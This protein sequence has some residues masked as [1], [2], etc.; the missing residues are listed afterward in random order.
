ME[1]LCVIGHPSFV[2]GADTELDHQIRC[3]VAM[4]KKVHICHT[5]EMDRNCLSMHL[6][7]RGCVYHPPR[8]WGSLEGLD[9]ISFCNSE[10]LKEL[11]E[12]TKF[13]RSTT[14][15]N[16][17]TFNFDAEVEMQQRGLI[18]FH[19]YQTEHAY[20]RVSKRLRDGNEYRPVM[21]KPYFYSEDFPFHENRPGDAFRFGRIS[22]ADPGKFHQSQLWI[23]ESMTAPVPKAGLIMGWSEEVQKK[24]G[25][26]AESYIATVSPGWTTAREFYRFC[27][28]VIMSTDT[29]ENLPRVGFEAMASGSVLV[30]DRRGGWENQV[31]SGKTGWLCE[32]DRD[33]VY[34]ASRLAHEVGEREAF[35]FA[36]REKL[37]R[38]WGIQAAMDSWSQVFDKWDKL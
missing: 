16:C 9:C 10:F 25:R 1:E 28:A 2:G 12:I 26:G 32:N 14:F 13:A 22:R 20:D 33:F 35:R 17:M 38:D 19:L 6:E 31:E 24:F 34:R 3:W 18:D 37:E 27:D 15:V 30:V 11:P 5:G 8:D 4:G 7:S 36:A 21:F 23:Y 29:F